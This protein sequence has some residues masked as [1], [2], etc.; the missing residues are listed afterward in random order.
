MIKILLGWASEWELGNRI[1][2]KN[3]HSKSLE[4]NKYWKMNAE[5][6]IG[7][8]RTKKKGKWEKSDADIFY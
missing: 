1:S 4:M 2:K 8:I 3:E 7:K 5:V 6:Q